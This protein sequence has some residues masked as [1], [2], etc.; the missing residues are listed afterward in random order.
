MLNVD[1]ANIFGFIWVYIVYKFVLSIFLFKNI[2]TKEL[3]IE[4][5]GCVKLEIN[6]MLPLIFVSFLNLGITIGL[7]F[8]FENLNTDNQDVNIYFSATGL[9]CFYILVFI[10]LFIWDYNFSENYDDIFDY[11]NLVN[12]VCLVTLLIL[13]FVY[14]TNNISTNFSTIVFNACSAF[15][16]L[17]IVLYRLYLKKLNSINYLIICLIFVLSL[18]IGNTFALFPWIF[19]QSHNIKLFSII[20]SCFCVL[21]L[22][23]YVIRYHKGY[24]KK[25][26]LLNLNI[27]KKQ[28]SE[29]LLNLDDKFDPCYFTNE[30]IYIESGLNKNSI[31]F[32]LIVV[33]F[34][35]L[36]TD[37]TTYLIRGAPNFPISFMLFGVKF[38]S[39]L[40]MNIDEQTQVNQFYYILICFGLLLFID[41]FSELLFFNSIDYTKVVLLFISLVCV[42]INFVILYVFKIKQQKYIVLGIV[43]TGCSLVLAIYYVFIMIIYSN[44]LWIVICSTS[45]IFIAFVCFFILGYKLKKQIDKFN[46][47]FVDKKFINV[48][49]G[50]LIAQLILLIIFVLVNPNQYYPYFGILNSV[51][52]IIMLV[53]IFFQKKSFN[54]PTRNLD[55]ELIIPNLLEIVNEDVNKN[56]IMFIVMVDVNIKYKIIDD[57]DDFVEYFKYLYDFILIISKRKIYGVRQELSE[58]GYYNKIMLV[59]DDSDKNFEENNMIDVYDLFCIVSQ[60]Y[61]K[62][63]LKE[64]KI[65]IKTLVKLLQYTEFTINTCS[66]EVFVDIADFVR[67]IS[68]FLQYSNNYIIKSKCLELKL[69]KNDILN[70]DMYYSINEYGMGRVEYIDQMK[71]PAIINIDD[72][73]DQNNLKKN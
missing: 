38:Y 26:K 10:V 24:K 15:V 71:N 61:D 56:F 59:N 60:T 6:Y 18:Y 8:C 52:S 14:L 25:L 48:C 5:L 51:V 49:I 62:K 33:C 23:V 9:A 40:I 1:N 53:S 22:L 67:Y 19:N 21:P 39:I 64:K 27:M 63:S 13:L 69:N 12:F 44:N 57:Y 66:S 46:N 41:F 55:E 36:I 2:E 17:G 68:Q 20:S 3:P 31:I 47:N 7:F 43:A 42:V 58:A 16:V 72:E 73:M 30:P 70:N 37:F 28:K 65:I 4:S 11:Q 35:I 50:I 32:N 54:I 45:F 29:F 34:C